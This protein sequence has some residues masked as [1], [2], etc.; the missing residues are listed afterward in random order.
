MDTLAAGTMHVLSA[1]A[2]RA[3]VTIACGITVPTVP[4]I[5]L[6]DVEPVRTEGA[7]QTERFRSAI[8]ARAHACTG[9]HVI[10]HPV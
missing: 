3:P 6:M 2:E 9:P 1:G 10:L 7:A 4:L 5:R 8:G